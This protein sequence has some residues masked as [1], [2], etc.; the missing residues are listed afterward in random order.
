MVYFVDENCTLFL[1]K[2]V[3][4]LYDNGRGFDTASKRKEHL[5]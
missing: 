5:L 1:D 3:L 2:T 4:L